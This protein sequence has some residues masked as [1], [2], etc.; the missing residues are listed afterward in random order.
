MGEA[1][2]I[3]SV[4]AFYDGGTFGQD[5]NLWKLVMTKAVTVL[6]LKGDT[7]VQI[8]PHT[9]VAVQSCRRRAC[10]R[11]AVLRGV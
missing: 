4:P 7:L 11:L 9:A 8:L 3:K 10:G 1:F 5:F 6:Q 2:L